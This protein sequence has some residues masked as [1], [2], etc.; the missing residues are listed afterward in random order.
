M[1]SMKKIIRL[2][3]EPR[4]SLPSPAEFAAHGGKF[5][6]FS[7]NVVQKL[8]FLNNFI[9]AIILTGTAALGFAQEAPAASNDDIVKLFEITNVKQSGLQTFDAML[10][11]MMQMVPDVPPDFFDAFRENLDFSSLVDALVPV[12][13]KYYTHDEV[14]QLIEFYRTPLGRKTIDV[15][16]A[17]TEESMAISMEWAL[18]LSQQM[19]EALKKKE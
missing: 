19:F 11:Q 9:I 5:S 8:R 3:Q 6:F 13:A 18:R 15:M 7:R 10:T 12:Y 17:I 16:P 1:F 14:M 4:G 2:V